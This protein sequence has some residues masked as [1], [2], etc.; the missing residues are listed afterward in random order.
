MTLYEEIAQIKTELKELN[1]EHILNMLKLETKD[2]VEFFKFAIQQHK[3][4][5]DISKE[6]GL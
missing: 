6:L 3:N 1:I 2:D 4:L 5:N